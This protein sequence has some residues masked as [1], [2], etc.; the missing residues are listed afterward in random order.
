MDFKDV[1]KELQDLGSISN[2][3]PNEKI[4]QHIDKNLKVVEDYAD[5]VIKDLPRQIKTALNR[6]DSVLTIKTA[7]LLTHLLTIKRLTSLGFP[8][9][10]LE[11]SF[12][13][14]TYD[15]KLQISDILEAAKGLTEV[16]LVVT[17]DKRF[18]TK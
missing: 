12:R 6:N 2:T 14:N 3:L 11:G 1:L 5:S 13:Y 9:K 7:N 4:Q 8:I 15:I 10:D 16:A 18:L 17:E